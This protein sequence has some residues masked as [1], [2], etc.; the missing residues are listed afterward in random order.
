MGISKLYKIFY[1][2]INMYVQHLNIL[3]GPFDQLLRDRNVSVYI[4]FITIYKF[5]GSIVGKVWGMYVIHTLKS[6]L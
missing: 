5:Q 3:T 6:F 2:L 4:A 1:L